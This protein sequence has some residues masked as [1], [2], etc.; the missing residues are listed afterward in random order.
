MAIHSN[1]CWRLGSGGHQVHMMK[2][3]GWIRPKMQ[4]WQAKPILI[5]KKSNPLQ[6]GKTTERLER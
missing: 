4:S 1:L 5:Q 2:I 6:T 3:M